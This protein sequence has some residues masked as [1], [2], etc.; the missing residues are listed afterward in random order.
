MRKIVKVGPRGERR[1]VRGK[2]YSVIKAAATAEMAAI[3]MA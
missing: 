1:P 3:T 2:S